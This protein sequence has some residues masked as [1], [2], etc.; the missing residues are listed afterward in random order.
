[1]GG[2]TYREYIGVPLLQSLHE[3]TKYFVSFYANFSG[4]ISERCATNKLGA[5]FTMQ[6]YSSAN[7]LNLNNHAEVF[8]DSIIK[9]TVNWVRVSDSFVADSNY[10]YLA[11]GN[12]FDDIHTDTIRLTSN[13]AF[14]SYYYIDDVCVTTDSLYNENWTTASFIEAMN[15]QVK[16]FP[17]PSSGV[18]YVQSFY[19]IN[20]LQVFNSFGQMV[21]ENNNIDNK[22]YSLD[23]NVLSSGIY[24]LRIIKSSGIPN[25]LKIN[26]IN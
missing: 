17:N 18:F 7:P 10:Q 6:Q 2:G 22:L 8:D 24:L 5:L 1:M 9:D 26:L 20:S 13:V 14:N 16:I 11:I 12:F 23:L 25:V 15:E 19:N 21:F 4:G 3:G